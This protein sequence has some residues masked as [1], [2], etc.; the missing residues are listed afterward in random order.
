MRWSNSDPFFPQTRDRSSEFQLWVNPLSRSFTRVKLQPQRMTRH[1]KSMVVG[2]QRVNKITSFTRSTGRCD[3]SPSGLSVR[4]DVLIL[5]SLQ[6]QSDAVGEEAEARLGQVGTA[7]PDKD[8]VQLVAKPV[9]ME[10]VAGCVFQ[11]L[12]G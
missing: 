7:L 10:H 4:K 9:Q 3:G 5:P 6:V 2:E 8:L 1:Y 11:L 12:V